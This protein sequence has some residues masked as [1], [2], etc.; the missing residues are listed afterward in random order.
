MRVGRA[1]L[2]LC[3]NYGYADGGVE[4]IGEITA[5]VKPSRWLTEFISYIKIFLGV[6]GSPPFRLCGRVRLVGSASSQQDEQGEGDIV[7][8]DKVLTLLN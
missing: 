8:S 6:S 4:N 3:W 7:G 2:C 5:F 1:R